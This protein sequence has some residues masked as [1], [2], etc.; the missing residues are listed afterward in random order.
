MSVEHASAR[1]IHQYARGDTLIATDEVWALESHLEG[2]GSCRERL[3]AAVATESP[4]LTSLLST[5]RSGL[6]PLLDEAAPMPRRRRWTRLSAWLTPVLAPW[7]F[8]PLCLTLIALLLE[9]VAPDFGEVSPLLL[10]APVLPLVGVAASWSRHLDPAHELTAATPR[11]GLYLLLRRTTCVLALL[12]PVLLVGGMVTGVAAAQWLLPALAFAAAALAL[13]SV[14]GVNR[15]VVSLGAVWGA[16]ILAPALITSR[17]PFV[18]RPEQLRV[19]GLLLV[20]GVGLLIAR[21]G[22]YSARGGSH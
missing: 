16:V 12:I 4:E 9:A 19:W 20:L 21:R 2:C 7:L 8:M 6:E 13:G 3:A 22:V 11:A 15:A 10:L 18:L 17:T 5:V 14:I 1:L